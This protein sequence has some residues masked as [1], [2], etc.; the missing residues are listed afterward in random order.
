MERRRVKHTA[1]LEERLEREAE[2]AR[3]QAKMLPR[4]EEQ[5]LLLRKARDA[6]AAI[7]VNRWLTSPGLRPPI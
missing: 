7:R 3:Q 1:S 6:D 2:R 4:G 5:E